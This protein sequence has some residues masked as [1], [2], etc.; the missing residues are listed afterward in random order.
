MAEEAK[1]P[2]ENHYACINCSHPV[3]ELCAFSCGPQGASADLSKADITY[4]DPGNTSLRKCP[5]CGDLLD[6]YTTL[7]FPVLLVDLLLCKTRCYRHL[8]INRGS[9]DPAQR[10]RDR[11][12]LMWRLGALVI[13]LDACEL[14]RCCSALLRC[15][16]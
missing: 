3:R 13:G 2:P 16:G 12:S 7:T 9:A 14:L 10:I 8:L 5:A 11:A 15:F 6:V 1:A 4:N